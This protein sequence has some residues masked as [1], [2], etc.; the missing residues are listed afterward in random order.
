MAEFVVD[1]KGE[2]GDL[3]AEVRGKL[4]LSLV[5]SYYLLMT[6]LIMRYCVQNFECKG[7]LNLYGCISNA[8]CNFLMGIICICLFTGLLK[9]CG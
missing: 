4:S 5:F 1:V 2:T 8:G 9:S 7:K 6:L 3:F